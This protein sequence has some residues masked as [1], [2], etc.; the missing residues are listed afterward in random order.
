MVQMRAVIVKDGKSETASGMYI[1]NIDRPSPKAGEVLVKV[2]A[3]GLNRMDI[4]QR[5]GKYPVPPQAP[6]TLGV[7]F[8]GTIEQVGGETQGGW[9]EGDE[10]FGLAFGGAYAEYIVVAEGMIT[11]KPH[12]VTHVQ[13]ASI[14]E[15]WLTAYQA[16]FLIAEL[17]KGQ[18]VLIHA[19]AS[20]VGLA[21]IQLAKVF[22][23]GL[24]IATA[25]TDDK[26][27]FVEQHGAKGINYKT[28]EFDKEVLALTDNV[29][30]NVVIDFVGQSYWEKNIASLARD[31]RMVLLGFLSGFVT[32]KPLDMGPI[33]YK[34]LRIQGTTLRS[35]TL[36][37]QSNL[38]QEFSKNAL[39]KVFA[40]CDG[41]KQGLDL[42]IHK[43]FDWNNIIE[44]HEEM[45]AAK[46]IGK[47]ICEIK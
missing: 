47:I 42:V 23:A 11:R 15:N 3:F 24:I 5:Q 31:G 46:N 6:S 36:E 43:V 14:P 29:G 37:Y 7:E 32:E 22:G 41:K 10:V 28:Q 20:G 45:E 34:R 26:V 38:L 2:E 16:L 18:S 25:G 12:S 39:D 30:V 8:S 19:G 35:R 1:G 27:K 44:A 40:S 4:A 33:L 13:A 9:K 17:T 21:A